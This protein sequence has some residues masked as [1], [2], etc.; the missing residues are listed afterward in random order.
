MV[1]DTQK[2]AKNVL[3]D[4]QIESTKSSLI[5]SVII[6]KIM[7]SHLYSIVFC[8]TASMSGFNLGYFMTIFNVVD[9]KVVNKIFYGSVLKVE[10]LTA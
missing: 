3:N 4:E 1:E 5:E 8:M 9:L 10:L 7:K 2:T 6:G